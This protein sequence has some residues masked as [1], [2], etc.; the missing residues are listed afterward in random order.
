MPQFLAELLKQVESNHAS[1]H[2]LPGSM[3]ET[4]S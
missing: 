3:Q 1:D 4:H 2:P